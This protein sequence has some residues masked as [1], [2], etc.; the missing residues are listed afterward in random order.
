M[1][2]LKY[3]RYN[4]IQIRF[5]ITVIQNKAFVILGCVSFDKPEPVFGYMWIA[6]YFYAWKH[7]N[8]IG[9]NML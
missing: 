9:K 2:I 4:S 7:S 1:G 3:D 6:I 5:I 8:T